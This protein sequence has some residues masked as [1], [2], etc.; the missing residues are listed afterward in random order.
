MVKRLHEFL[1]RRKGTVCPVLSEI[2]QALGDTPI[3]R[4]LRGEGDLSS[5]SL[6]YQ[7]VADIQAYLLADVRGN[8]DMVFSLD[9]NKCHI[10]DE[11]SERTLHL[12]IS[13]SRD[14]VKQPEQEVVPE[15][16]VDGGTSLPDSISNN[17]A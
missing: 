4:L 9:R 7:D 16:C 8:D 13:R 6:C 11:F 10:D 12:K 2:G 14:A 1:V 5:L 3:E 17:N 15:K